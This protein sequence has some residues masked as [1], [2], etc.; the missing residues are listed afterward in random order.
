MPSYNESI[1]ESLRLIY[2]CSPK[3]KVSIDLIQKLAQ[4]LKL[5]TFIDTE[6][7]STPTNRNHAS[8]GLKRLSIA[9]SL[10]L[11]DIDFSDN[12][13]VSKVS[14]SSGNHSLTIDESDTELV[15]RA[16]KYTSKQSEYTINVVF[17]Q[18]NSLSFLRT[19]NDS[20]TVA[21]A[22]LLK[23]LSNN[24][25]GNF[26]TNLKYLTCLDSMSPLDGDLIVYLDNIAL[27]LNAV[28]AMETNLNPGIT[29]ICSGWKSRFGKVY[30]NDPE[31]QRLGVFLHFWKESRRLSEVMKHGATP[32]NSRVHKAILT[33]EEGES[34]S[35]DVLKEAKDQKWHL[36][37]SQGLLQPYIFTFEDDSHLHN[38]QSVTSFSSPNW[39]LHL[40]LDFPV[41]MPS[42]LI[43]YFGI[44]NYGQ[45]KKPREPEVFKLL[46]EDGAVQF[47]ARMNGE[48]ISISFTADDTAELVAVES[49]E[50][51]KLTQLEKIIPTIRNYIV[52]SSLVDNVMQSPDTTFVASPKLSRPISQKLKDSLN[53]SEGVTDE[54]LLNLNTLASGESMDYV[55]FNSDTDLTNFVKQE[56]NTPNYSR[57]CDSFDAT[58]NEKRLTICLKDIELNSS[59][60]EIELNVQGT[61]GSGISVN[62]DFK[63][64]NGDI[65]NLNT[66]GDIHMDS[67]G[68]RGTEYVTALSLCEDPLLALHMIEGI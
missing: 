7:L 56:D 29:D 13:T 32:C 66:S 8:S 46:K 17:L 6:V 61:V 9:G 1:S 47:L 50:I 55:M 28:H 11:I 27:Y 53:L 21:E 26:P 60:V 63:I 51:T 20:S 49:F 10:I 3:F 40:R 2:E 23:N 57:D 35:L 37:T 30:L 25:L 38:H 19:R 52:F 33:I 36:S 5:E 15:E 65:T 41:F 43:E 39:A 14:L 59:D 64:I 68:N 58:E 12:E 45:A 62:T 42:V 18:A 54:E 48:N 16:S 31:T 34:Q 22:I 24:V 67:E 4:F 44:T